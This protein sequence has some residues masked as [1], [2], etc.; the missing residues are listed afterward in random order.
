[1]S[2]VSG[3]RVVAHKGRPSSADQGNVISLEALSAKLK[4]TNGA[5]DQMGKNQL[6]N[7]GNEL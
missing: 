1:V 3:V 2:K 5:F 6:I 7:Y 4:A